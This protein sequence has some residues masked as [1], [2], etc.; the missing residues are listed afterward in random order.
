MDDEPTPSLLVVADDEDVLTSLERGL[1][2]SGFDMTSAKTGPDALGVLAEARPQA[3]VVDIDQ[4]TLRGVSVVSAVRSVDNRI[5]V[6]VLS[7]RSAISDRVPG[8]AEGADDFM[9]KPYRLSELVTRVRGLLCPPVL[10]TNFSTETISVGPLMVETGRRR[11][12]INGIEIQLT[13]R[14][15]D[16][17]AVLAQHATEILSRARLLELVWG[18]SHFAADTRVV[19][20]FIDSVRSKLDLVCGPR[21][22]HTVPSAGFV[23]RVQQ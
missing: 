18:N 8:L 3:V 21:L 6:C 1:R 2:L 4:P 9:Y 15:F 11:A 20:A 7:G 10:V 14:E 13:R 16:L 17:L 23:L 5:P 19:D 22:L 12:S